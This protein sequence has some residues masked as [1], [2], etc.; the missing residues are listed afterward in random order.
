MDGHDIL[1]FT[2]LEILNY[3]FIEAMFVSLFVLM[4]LWELTNGK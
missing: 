1:S 3:Y 4:L 2:F